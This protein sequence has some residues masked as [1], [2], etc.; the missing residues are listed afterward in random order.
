M[1]LGIL[2]L[3]KFFNIL[4]LIRLIPIFFKYIKNSGNK[5]TVKAN[6]A[7]KQL[8]IFNSW[9]ILKKIYKNKNSEKYSIRINPYPPKIKYAVE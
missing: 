5:K 8:L 6:T 7:E 4:K 9:K 3:Y 2:K 1:G